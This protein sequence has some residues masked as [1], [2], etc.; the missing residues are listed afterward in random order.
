MIITIDA[1]AELESLPNFEH[2]DDTFRTKLQGGRSSWD[3]VHCKQAFTFGII[4]K[5]S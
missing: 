2:V 3:A 1:F 5:E 4:A